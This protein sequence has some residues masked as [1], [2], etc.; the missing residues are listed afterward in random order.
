[1]D[2]RITRAD[3][4]RLGGISRQAVS[5]AVGAGKLTFKQAKAD[6]IELLAEWRERRDPARP[7]KLGPALER[8]IG[9]QGREIP[10]DRPTRVP[11][12][13]V[14]DEQDDD[15]VPG[16]LSAA[17]KKFWRRVER[18]YELDPDALLILRTACEAWDRA[19][20][21]RHA[22][23]LDGLIINGRRHAAVDVE[24]QSQSLFLR[25]MR[26]LGLDVVAPGRLG[27]PAGKE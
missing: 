15:G 24:A 21:A 3:L 8:A 13:D 22:I 11:I 27:R 4:A 19:Q 1:M 2:Y 7:D 10:A 6:P 14:A 12:A 17:M 18:E 25:A 9:T 20:Q 16:H 23:D 5:H 26:Q